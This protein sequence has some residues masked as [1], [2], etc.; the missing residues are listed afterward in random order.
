MKTFQQTYG[1]QPQVTAHAPG[2]VNLIGEHTDYSDGFVL[3]IALEQAATAMISRSS[4]ALHHL[5]APDTGERYD[6]LPDAP[7]EGLSKYV[8]GCYRVLE[9]YFHMVV[10][11]L[12][13]WVTSSVPTGSGLS[14]SAALE[15]STLRA[16]RELLNLDLDDV[17]LARL[18]QRA[19]N[20]WA[21]VPCG[22]MDQMASSVANSSTALF[23]DTFTL[24]MRQIP[25]PAGSEILVINSGVVHENSDGGYAQRRHEVEESAR[26]LGVKALRWVEDWNTLAPLEGNIK[27]CARHVVTENARVLEA[28]TADA[29]HFGILMNASHAS[30]RD[31]FQNSTPGVDALVEILQGLSGV[32]GA[33]MTGGGFGGCVVALVVSGRALEVGRKAVAQHRAAGYEGYQVVPPVG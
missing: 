1:H 18:A 3:P 20:M 24:E 6:L 7:L 21:G 17:T 4:D 22:I 28:L 13:Y 12:N 14:S 33:R 19:E 16:V 30:M 15:V 29:G 9:E 11:P 8:L 23:L 5:Y 26:A 25:L 27:R 10:P 2:R 31:D 32:F